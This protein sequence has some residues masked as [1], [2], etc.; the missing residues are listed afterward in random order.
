MQ[1]DVPLWA[2]W[3]ILTFLALLNFL[4]GSYESA[5]LGASRF[6][7]MKVLENAPSPLP[8]FS[9]APLPMIRPY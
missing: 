7:I 3:L 1:D 6:R 9:P 4:S 8:P 5:L 2:D